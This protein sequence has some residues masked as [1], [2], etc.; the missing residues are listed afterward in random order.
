MS[1]DGITMSA[2]RRE[3]ASLLSGAKLKKIIQPRANEG[4]LS[5][6]TEK[7]LFHCSAL[8]TRDLRVST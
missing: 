5:F 4:I 3:L 6:R 1:F 8:P 7:E 2:V